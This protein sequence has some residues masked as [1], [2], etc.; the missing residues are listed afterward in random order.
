MSIVTQDLYGHKISLLCNP[1]ACA[2]NGSRNV[3]PVP[4]PIS[5]GGARDGVVSPGGTSP[6]LLDSHDSSEGH[7]LGRSTKHGTH[8]MPRQ[9]SGV[10]DVRV[11]VCSSGAVIHVGPLGCIRRLVWL[12]DPGNAPAPGA[13]VG[14]GLT[15]SDHVVWFDVDL[16][17]AVSLELNQ[18]GGNWS[19]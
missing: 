7:K 5:V 12:R 9:N 17:K 2:S 13:C 1:V 4:H 16:A 11:S 8:L 3:G 10:Q 15:G 19:K 6:E 18:K 14:N